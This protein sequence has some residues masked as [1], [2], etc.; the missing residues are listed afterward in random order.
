MVCRGTQLISKLL[1]LP[2]T[3]KKSLLYDSIPFEM[4]RSHVALFT[5]PSCTAQVVASIH[6]LILGGSRF[7]RHTTHI[8]CDWRGLG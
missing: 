2:E 6:L 1:M 5:L 7:Q 4:P 8:E 3:T